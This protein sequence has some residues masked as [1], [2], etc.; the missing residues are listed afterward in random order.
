[1]WTV[2]TLGWN[3]AT[4]DQIHAR[5]MNAAKPGMIVLM[6]VGAESQDAFALDRVISSLKA[7][8]YGFGTVAE[9][10]AP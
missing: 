5:T 3:G 8:G 2:D 1:M 10:I 9:V 4:V 7:A 6:H